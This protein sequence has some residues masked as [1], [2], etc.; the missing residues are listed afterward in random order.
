LFNIVGNTKIEDALVKCRTILNG[1]GTCTTAGIHNF[2]EGNAIFFMDRL[3]ADYSTNMRMREMDDKYGLLPMPKYDTNQKNYATTAQ[4]YFTLMFVLNHSESNIPTKG[5]AVSAFLQYATEMSY[6]SVR[7]YYFNRIIKP[8]FF[9]NDD[10]EG[11]VSRSAA[12]FDI[13]VK[14]VEFDFMTIYSPHLNNIS[15]L[16]RNACRPGNSDTMEQLY[17]NQKETFNRALLDVD[18]WLGLR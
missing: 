9:G 1:E 12:L 14:N 6:D 10:S 13:I 8:K 16:W 15:H 18:R 7:G 2:A 5:E 3:Y 17:N 11:T 4:D